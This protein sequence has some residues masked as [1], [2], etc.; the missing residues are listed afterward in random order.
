MKYI[1]IMKREEVIVGRILRTV[2]ALFAVCFVFSCGNPERTGTVQTVPVK[3]DSVK[4]VSEKKVQEDF[5]SLCSSINSSDIQKY[6]HAEHGVWII[7]SPGAVPVMK[8]VKE[9]PKD[10]T[11]D[12]SSVKEGELPKIDCSSKTL[13]TKTGCFTQEANTFKDEKIW[14]YCGLSKEDEGK[15][16]QLAQTISHTVVNTSVGKF[17]FSQIAGTWYII[18]MDLRKP[19][20]A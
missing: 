16:E 19:C 9:F 6:I 15:V 11:I 1:F 7:D 2:F 3:T 12:F 20:E 10:L 17:Y 4:P 13:W 8:L 5:V 14:K 18:F